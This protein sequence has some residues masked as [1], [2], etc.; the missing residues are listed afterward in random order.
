MCSSVIPTFFLHPLLLSRRNV[1]NHAHVV[2]SCSLHGCRSSCHLLPPSFSW[3]LG[4][5]L[6]TCLGYSRM[7]VGSRVSSVGDCRSCWHM[8]PPSSH[9]DSSIL[10]GC[11][12]VYC[13]FMHVR[14]CVFFLLQAKFRVS[15][16]LQ[17]LG[18][19]LKRSL[20]VF[21]LLLGYGISL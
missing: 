19:M 10:F 18:C 20:C 16:A 21:A 15:F 13:D 4:Y 3:G 8:F 14:M 12:R 6:F 11:F 5:S 17:Q 1:L 2:G 9:V 7:Y